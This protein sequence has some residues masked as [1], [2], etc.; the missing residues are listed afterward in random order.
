MKHHLNTINAPRGYI[1]IFQI[2]LNKLE[3][4]ITQPRSNIIHIA[5]TQIINH[6]HTKTPSHQSI[7]QVG[8]NK[9]RP[10]RH[11][12]LRKTPHFS[13]SLQLR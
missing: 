4:W 5:I 12:N 10:T 6:P 1:R 11:K 9:T 3:L 7:N 8:A 2:S 13:N